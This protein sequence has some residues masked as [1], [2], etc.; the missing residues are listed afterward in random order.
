[1]CRRSPPDN[2]V[3]EDIIIIDGSQHVNVRKLRA[4]TLGNPV[5]SLNALFRRKM[6][7]N[8][9]FNCALDIQNVKFA[10]WLTFA[11][12]HQFF[13]KNIKIMMYQAITASNFSDGRPLKNHE[14][15]NVGKKRRQAS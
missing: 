10:T 12:G 15:G 9:A 2:I 3:T 4:Q 14:T 8:I 6:T 13:K 5:E 1:M 11:F 7:H